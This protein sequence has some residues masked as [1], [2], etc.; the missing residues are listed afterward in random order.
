[1]NLSWYRNNLTAGGLPQALRTT[2]PIQTT[3]F[4]L[5]NWVCAAGVNC[6]TAADRTLNP[7]NPFASAVGD[8]L[9]HAAQ[10]YYRFGEA[11]GFT[12]TR[13]S[14]TRCCV[15]RSASAE[16]LATA[17]TSTVD[18]TASQSRLRSTADVI[19][20]AGFTQAIATG[21]YNLIDPTLNNQAVRDSVILTTLHGN[22]GGFT[23]SKAW[24]RR[25]CS[26][27]RGSAASSASAGHP[28]RDAEQSE[29]QRQ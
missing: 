3:T 2:S 14:A 4:V 23:R 17:S 18:G 20:L 8:P 10:L 13:A 9:T 12:A 25:S 1:M 24:S 27:F 28:A 21:Q 6:D 15:A 29:C 7:Y 22:V 16:R 26:S 19:S 5:P 11:D